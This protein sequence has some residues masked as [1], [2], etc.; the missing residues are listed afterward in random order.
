MQSDE[1]ALQLN[2]GLLFLPLGSFHE[3]NKSC[4]HGFNGHILISLLTLT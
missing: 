2:A 3:W 4:Q 1:T